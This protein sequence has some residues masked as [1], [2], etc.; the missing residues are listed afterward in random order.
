M[1]DRFDDRVA[2]RLRMLRAQVVHNDLAPTNVLVD[3]EW[4]VT[5]ITDFGDMTHTALVC[6]VAVTAADLVPDRPDRMDLAVEVVAGYHCLTPLELPEAKP[7]PT[8]SPPA[9]PPPS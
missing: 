3:D 1:L 4:R 7:S 9:T 5:G 6:D 8:S 2:P